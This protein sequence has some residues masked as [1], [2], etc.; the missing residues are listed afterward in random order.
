MGPAAARIEAGF[1][2]DRITAGKGSLEQKEAEKQ[3]QIEAEAASLAKAD[4][5]LGNLLLAYVKQLEHQGKYEA[6]AIKNS[7]IKNVQ[8]AHPDKWNSLADELTMPD[9]RDIIATLVHAE[10]YRE[11]QKVRAYLR[12]AFASAI[13]AHGD[14]AAIPELRLFNIQSNPVRDLAPVT[15]P[16]SNGKVKPRKPLSLDELRCYW[17]RISALPDP[18]GAILRLHLL[19]G[20][21]RLRQLCR[22]TADDVDGDEITLHDPKG[23]R[24]EERDHV[25]PLLK[26]AREALDAIDASTWLVS[27]DGG[28][29][30][31]DPWHVSKRVK[32]IAEAMLEAE[33]T[34][35][36]FTGKIIRATVET[37]LTQAGISPHILG[38]LLSHGLGTLQEKHYQFYDFGPEKIHALKTLLEL[39]TEKPGKVVP[40][41]R[42]AKQ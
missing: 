5:T 26:D 14:A 31:A 22:L 18:D 38:H 23:R 4:Y 17:K 12:A 30:P 19:T 33:E 3:K 1:E 41:K 35:E 28:K 10:K 42:R 39:L 6:R 40:I 13:R 2:R 37:R 8:V 27:F 11:A 15:K 20:G 24:V 32:A 7:L 34:H 36:I 29:T 21:Q 16:K 25:V 9:F